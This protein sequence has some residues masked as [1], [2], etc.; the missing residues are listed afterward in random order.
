MQYSILQ[1]VY[2]DLKR[3]YITV[4]KNLKCEGCISKI[5]MKYSCIGEHLEMRI[6]LNYFVGLVVTLLLLCGR[7]Y[8]A[9][10]KTIK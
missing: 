1:H 4:D 7:K 3:N 2:A 5:C 6:K 9:M 10:N 8:P